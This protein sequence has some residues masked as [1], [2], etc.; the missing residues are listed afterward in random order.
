MEAQ[1]LTMLKDL[2]PTYDFE[3]NADFIEQGYLDSFDVVTLVA[4]LEEA[5]S[6]SISALDIIPENFASVV[7]ICELVQRS[8]KNQLLMRTDTGRE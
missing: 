2:Q 4:E 6:V 7:S 8:K 3:E 5:F 1:I